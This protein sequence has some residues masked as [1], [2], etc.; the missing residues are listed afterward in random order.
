MLYM[1]PVCPI[2]NSKY[3][4]FGSKF[5]VTKMRTKPFYVGFFRDSLNI[6]AQTIILE[7]DEA[8]VYTL[9]MFKYLSA[10]SKYY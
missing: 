8:I 3:V 10:S 6:R 4:R 2:C 1:Q 9:V 7:P 5:E